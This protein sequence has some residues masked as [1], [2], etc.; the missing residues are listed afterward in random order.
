MGCVAVV[1]GTACSGTDDR[2]GTGSTTGS[3]RADATG[4]SDSGF[5]PCDE[6]E[7]AEFQQIFGEQFTAVK[8][9]GTAA[10][11]TIVARDTAI[12]E[13]LTVRDTRR[14]GYG[15]D[16]ATAR[17]AAESDQL[18]PAAVHDVEGIGDRA[19][20]VSTCDP[21]ERPNESLHLELDGSHIAYSAFFVPGDRIGATEEALTALARRQI[22]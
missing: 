18:C 4:A 9:G 1:V 14:A 21:K 22:G 20:Y 13:S 3:P 19:F 6:V 8:V 17:S 5:G 16:F 15:E 11:C 10:D 7:L 12:G 2:A